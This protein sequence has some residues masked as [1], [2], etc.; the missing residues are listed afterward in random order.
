[1]LTLSIV[2]TL[3]QAAAAV[4]ADPVP[5]KG[6]IA[7]T[8]SEIRAYNANLSRS[9]PAYVRCERSSITGSL[10]R[11]I[12]TCRTNAEWSKVDDKGNK[13]ARDFVDNMSMGGTRDG[14]AGGAGTG[15]PIGP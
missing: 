12:T 8:S 14:A 7:M 10:T 3:S 4:P 9:D 5:L 1:M 2:L 13:F 11:K 15:S 6:P